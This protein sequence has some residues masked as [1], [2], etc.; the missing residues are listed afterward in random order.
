MGIR[1]AQEIPGR[2]CPLGHGIRLSLRGA[3]AAGT[4]GIHPFRYG[5]QPR[6]NVVNPDD[7][8]R[9]YGADTLRTYEMF[10]GASLSSRRLR[11]RD[12]WY[13]PIPLWP[14]AETPRC[15][16]AHRTPPPE[17]SKAAR[18]PHITAGWSIPR[19]ICFIPGSGTDSSTIRSRCPVRSLIKRLPVVCGLI[20][21]HLRK[22]QRQL[23][24]R[25]RY[26]AA[27]F[28]LYNGNGFAP[29]TLSGKHPVPKLKSCE[30]EGNSHLDFR[31]CAHDLWNGRHHGGSGT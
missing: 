13:S 12:R 26:I 7:I 9:E 5:R 20:G 15:L 8:V 19:C 3:S 16:W 4:G 11:S 24:L 17:A 28:T 23:A 27:L 31:L 22:H 2:A 6:G 29:V 30:R 21:L 14:P 10:I 1:I 25:K 18:S